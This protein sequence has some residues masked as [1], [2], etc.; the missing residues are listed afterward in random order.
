MD[1][2]FCPVEAK[3]KMAV[4][5]L[6]LQDLLLGAVLLSV[7]RRVAQQYQ[8]KEVFH[9]RWKKQVSVGLTCGGLPME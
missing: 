5:L 6:E 9:L 2:A 8:I 4:G 3:L 7:K 1:G